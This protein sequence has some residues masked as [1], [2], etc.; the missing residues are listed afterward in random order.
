MW[1]L[2]PNHGRA[3]EEKRV[4]KGSSIREY[5]RKFTGQRGDM[6]VTF[7]CVLRRAKLRVE[8][9][10]QAQLRYPPYTVSRSGAKRGTSEG[11]KQ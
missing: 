4:Q 11:T 5:P 7:E 2:P 6:R 9:F 10:M 8:L 1:T 3:R